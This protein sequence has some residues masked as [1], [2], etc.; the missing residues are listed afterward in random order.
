MVVAVAGF[1][2]IAPVGI[3][4]GGADTGRLVALD[5]RC[6]GGSQSGN[7]KENE[8]YQNFERT[9]LAPLSPTGEMDSFGF[10]GLALRLGVSLATLLEGVKDTQW[11]G[12]KG[13][14]AAGALLL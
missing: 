9:H 5:G 10:A 1:R 13:H 4:F 2:A 6:T 7:T 3:E 8:E 11:T 14:F 12:T